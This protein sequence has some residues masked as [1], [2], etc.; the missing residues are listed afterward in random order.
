M[1]DYDLLGSFATG[2]AADLNADLINKLKNADK[3][4]VLFQIDKDLEGITGLDA[5]TGDELDKL[6]ELDTLLNVKIHTLDLMS[7]VEVFDLSSTST[8]AFDQ[9]VASTTGSAAVFDAVDV[10]GLEPGTTNIEVTQLA[11]KD[12]YQSISFNG[13]AKEAQMSALEPIPADPDDLAYIAAAGININIDGEDHFFH[14]VQDPSATTVAELGAKTIEELADEI[15]ENEKLI[16][17]IE[18]VGTDEYR[19]VIKSADSGMDNALTITQTNFNIGFGE[20]QQSSEKVDDTSELIAGGQEGGDEISVN[21]V[22]FSTVG[23]TYEQLAADINDYDGGGGAGDTFNA[24]IAD[25][26]IVI[27]ADDG[28]DIT[29]TQTDVDLGFY[30][31]TGQTQT[32]QNL[33]ANVDGVD[34]DVGSN[35][36][37]IQGNLTMTAVEIGNSTIDIQKDNSSILT[38][39][40]NVIGSYNTLVDL[41]EDE[42]SDPDSNISDASSLRSILSAIK[43]DLFSSYGVNGDLNLFSHGLDIDLQGHLSIDSEKFADGLNDNYDD[44]KSLLMGNTTDSDLAESDSTKSLG[45]GYM[46]KSYLDEL[47]S[48]DGLLTRYETSLTERQTELEKEREEALETL[49]L[50]YNTM[51]K[52]FSDY[53]AL[54]TQMESAFSGLQMMIQ[55]SVASK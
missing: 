9:V 16:A 44:I 37:T 25:G 46:L 42:L 13:D 19:L 32:A 27:T 3:E 38:S 17:S 35:T 39:L 31:S 24:S 2:G 21:G 4:S 10:S 6:G 22:V 54:I 1:A 43:E 8:T 33:I 30:D 14:I 48:N 41:I 53:G 49:D 7:K 18:T 50:K 23:K 15:N 12:V 52:Q 51:A 45:L 40:E 29:I 47:D 26:Q 55:Q 36:M 5:E 28:S 11:Q 34:Y 20:T